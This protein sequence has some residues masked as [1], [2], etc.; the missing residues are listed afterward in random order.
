MTTLSIHTD[1]II[2]ISAYQLSGLTIPQEY[3]FQ[4][5]WNFQ[6]AGDV[7]GG[8]FSLTNLA[9]TNPT[10]GF[11]LDNMHWNWDQW[12]L[13]TVG[14][15]QLDY[16][17]HADLLF[18]P[19]IVGHLTAGSTSIPISM[20]PELEIGCPPL[21]P[22]C[23]TYF[24]LGHYAGGLAGKTIEIS[25]WPSRDFADQSVPEPSIALWFGLGLVAGIVL[26]KLRRR[27]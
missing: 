11:D 18:A 7:T 10:G 22:S 5:P 8:N 25:V 1:L 3:R 19:V 4:F 6:A 23:D 20:T 16:Q 26:R 12:T 2:G 13:N 9:Y 14:Q 17:G 27:V 21:Y 24:I 15:V